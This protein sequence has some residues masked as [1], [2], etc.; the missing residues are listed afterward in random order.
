MVTVRIIYVQHI[1]VMDVCPFIRENYSQPCS[2]EEL[3]F[4]SFERSPCTK[5]AHLSN[6]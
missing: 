6:P 2:G 3:G 5:G 1:D 4:G